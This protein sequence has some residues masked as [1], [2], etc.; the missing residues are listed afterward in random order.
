MTL[1]LRHRQ[2]D[3]AGAQAKRPGFLAERRPGQLVMKIR[4]HQESDRLADHLASG[5]PPKHLGPCHSLLF[6]R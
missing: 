4:I 5:M 3:A 1:Y 6:L 2:T